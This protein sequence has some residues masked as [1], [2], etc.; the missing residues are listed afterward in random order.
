MCVPCN[1]ISWIVIMAYKT[2]LLVKHQCDQIFYKIVASSILVNASIWSNNE[3]LANERSRK[4]AEQ[5]ERIRKVAR[6]WLIIEDN[7]SLYSCKNTE[8]PQKGRVLIQ[9]LWQWCFFC[10]LVTFQS[11]TKII[12]YQIVMLVANFWYWCRGLSPTS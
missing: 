4:E 12:I 8:P 3:V 1:Q 5:M 7:F 2:L 11:I 9:N 6:S 10:V